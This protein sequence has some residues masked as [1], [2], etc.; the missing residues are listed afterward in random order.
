[1]DEMEEQS[2]T[3]IDTYLTVV[4]TRAVILPKCGGMQIPSSSLNRAMRAMVA[5]VIYAE[6]DGSG[7]NKFGVEIVNEKI[8]S[9]C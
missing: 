9:V 2:A 8:S 5:W 1:M 7:A 6:S 4:D 3:R